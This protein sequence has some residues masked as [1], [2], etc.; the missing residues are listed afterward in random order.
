MIITTMTLPEV[1]HEVMRDYDS[2]QRRCKSALK[3][4]ESEMQ[5]SQQFATTRHYEYISPA[6]NRW[7]IQV[8]T[9]RVEGHHDISYFIRSYDNYGLIAFSVLDN[10]VSKCLVKYS[11]HFLKRYNERMKMNESNMERLVRTYFKKNMMAGC[12]V[13]EVCGFEDGTNQVYIPGKEGVALGWHD[14][15]KNLMCIK[16]FVRN[17]MLKGNQVEF[18]NILKGYSDEIIENVK[19]D[20]ELISESKKKF[21]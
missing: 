14:E 11:T 6:K 1:Y 21:V 13:G 7:L 2:V 5:R 19:F 4:L 20:L 12:K 16:T 15:A 9:N 18:V 3:T 10:G 17:D 8:K